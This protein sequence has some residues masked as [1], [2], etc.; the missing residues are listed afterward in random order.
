MAAGGGDLPGS[1]DRPSGVRA[2]VT[3]GDVGGVVVDSAETARPGAIVVAEQTLYELLDA[4]DI[5]WH[6]QPGQESIAAMWQALSA[7]ELDAYSRIVIF[8]DSL[9]ADEAD[10]ADEL[11]QTAWAIA[12]MAGAGARVF[13]AVWRPERAARLDQEILDAAA[14]QGLD[15]SAL[16]YHALPAAEPARVVLRTLQDVLAHEVTFPDRWTGSID[17]PL[18]RAGERVVGLPLRPPARPAGLPIRP[19]GGVVDEPTA[20]DR[21]VDEPGEAQSPVDATERTFV[22]EVILDDGWPRP[23]LPPIVGAVVPVAGWSPHYPPQVSA[24]LLR[25]PV[26][27][28]QVT[29]AVTSSKGG[30]GK[31]TVSVLL[32]A[33]IARDSAA[34]GHRL[35]VV[36]VDL[37]TYHGQISSIVGTFMPTALNIRVQPTWDEACIRHSIVRAE[38]LGV[39]VLLAPVR[40]RTA[41]IV[42]PEFYRP[43]IASLKRMYDVVVLDT[44]N[45]YLDPLVADVALGEADRILFVTTMAATSVQGMA[46][47]LADLTAPTDEGG[48]GVPADR[49]AIVVNQAAG[50]VG[51]DSASLVTAGLGVPIVGA[52]PLA[53]KDVLTATNNG[54]MVD[55]LDHRLLGPAYNEL[56]RTCLP[57]RAIEP[58]RETVGTPPA[59]PV[60][61]LPEPAPADA[62]GRRGLFRR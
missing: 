49:I 21:P 30:A 8:S 57:S 56:A 39:D 3:D 38:R 15:G 26:R 12:A 18:S 60:F 55:L 61:T 9:R 6:L 50:G 1:A 20:P 33:S 23:G 4:Q 44:G 62:A 52:V 37:D 2:D 28:G 11:A 17:R 29:I 13:V 32:A 40:P 45:H 35:S 7:G 53:T 36:V 43:I 31:T 48:Q 24:E 41:Q 5:G 34:A 14:A 16:D 47:A 58:W 25:R 59:G 42:G 46:R 27:T 51:I 54:R 10:D 22:R 19:P